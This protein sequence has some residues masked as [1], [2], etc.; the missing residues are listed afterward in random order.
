[1]LPLLIVLGSLA[2]SV[3][4]AVLSHGQVMVLL[5]PLV[6]G[7]PLAGLARRRR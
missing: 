7:L 2:L 3:V 4:V 1:M 5:L 6:L